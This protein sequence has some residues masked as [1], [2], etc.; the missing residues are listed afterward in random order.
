MQSHDACR[1]YRDRGAGRG[2]PR[3]WLDP[4][5]CP[6]TFSAQSGCNELAWMGH[7]RDQNTPRSTLP[8]GEPPKSALSA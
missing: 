6:D 7:L 8:Y 2:G 4:N 3:G 1:G 5:E